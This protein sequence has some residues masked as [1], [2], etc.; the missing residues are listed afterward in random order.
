MKIYANMLGGADDLIIVS[1]SE[2]RQQL[3]DVFTRFIGTG[4]TNL[5]SPEDY[6]FRI[7][8]SD[9]GNNWIRL[10][11]AA[12]IDFD[13]VEH[14]DYWEYSSLMEEFGFSPMS[15]EDYFNQKSPETLIERMNKVLKTYNP[16]WYFDMYDSCTIVAG[17]DNC[18]L[19]A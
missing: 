12:E 9:E 7:D 3:T 4:D 18:I 5:A 16:S 15:K 10:E 2:L 11:V 19:E 17:L 6:F 14:L 13:Y 8:F 1:E